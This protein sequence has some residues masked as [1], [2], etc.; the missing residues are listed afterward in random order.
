M[1]PYAAIHVP[2]AASI[3]SQL[4]DLESL[5]LSYWNGSG[6]VSAGFNGSVVTNPH[7]AARKAVTAVASMARPETRLRSSFQAEG[8]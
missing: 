6:W 3:E 1:P 5:P 7:Y 2:T 4:T 8:T